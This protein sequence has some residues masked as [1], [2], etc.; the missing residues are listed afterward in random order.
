M[1]NFVA[2]LCC[3]I[4]KFFVQ[5]FLKIRIAEV[6]VH[7]NIRFGMANISD[8]IRKMFGNFRS[9]SFLFRL[10]RGL[11]FGILQNLREAH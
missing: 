3:K 7:E 11:Q 8:S 2:M 4:E 5:Y 9:F 6:V 10:N 1:R